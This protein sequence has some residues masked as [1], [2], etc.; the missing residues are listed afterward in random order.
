MFRTNVNEMN[1]DTIDLGDEL[2]HGI[3]FRFNLAPVVFCRPIARER[4]NR[5]EL[6]ALRCIRD[7][8]SVRPPGCFDA[9]A[10]FGEFCFRN[11]DMKWADFVEVFPGDGS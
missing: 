2:R 7:S 9:P 4:L 10:Q 11:I 1:V 6:H 5:G 3:E 8:L